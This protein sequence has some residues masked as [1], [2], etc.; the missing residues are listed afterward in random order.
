MVKGHFIKK[1]GTFRLNIKSDFDSKN[2]CG[3]HLIVTAPDLAIV[4][5]SISYSVISVVHHILFSASIA[6]R[7]SEGG[8][9]RHVRGWEKASDHAPVWIMLDNKK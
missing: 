5:C 9:N 6:V 2:Y 7:L 3:S 8:I 1:A 4:K